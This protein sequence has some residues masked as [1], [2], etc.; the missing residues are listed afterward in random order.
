[1]N[2]SN[3]HRAF[4]FRKLFQMCFLTEPVLSERQ[5]KDPYLCSIDE[6]RDL[7]KITQLEIGKICNCNVYHRNKNEIEEQQPAS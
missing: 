6:A 4:Q 7:L 5:S 1:M 3:T 2:D